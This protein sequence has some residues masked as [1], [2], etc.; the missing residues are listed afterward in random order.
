V[1]P[2]KSIGTVLPEGGDEQR[3]A[4]HIA[5][6]PVVAGEILRAGQKVA[7]AYG[8]TSTV[9]RA[10]DDYEAAQRPS[11]GIIDP[12]LD[13][14][15]VKPG[16]RVW[17]F[18]HPNSVT[19]MRHHWQHPAVDLLPS[20]A[21]TESETWLHRFAER[22]GFN[23]DEMMKTASD[24]TAEGFPYIIAH[25]KDLHSVGELGDDH[26]LFWQHMALLT[27]RAFDHEHRNKVGWSCTC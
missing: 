20:N 23:Y 22:W 4:I 19:G 24:P 1:G 5:V 8:S 17:L 2:I 13:E 27:G 12:F 3:D 6:L 9:I 11:V 7:F 26:E 18:L 14:W 15:M 10:L 16:Q 25:G 21:A